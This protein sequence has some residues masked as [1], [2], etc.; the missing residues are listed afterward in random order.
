MELST[1]MINTLRVFPALFWKNM[2]DN[3]SKS[4]SRSQLSS[5]VSM[6]SAMIWPRFSRNMSQMPPTSDQALSRT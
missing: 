2:N 3:G 4:H 5:M 6:A 1:F